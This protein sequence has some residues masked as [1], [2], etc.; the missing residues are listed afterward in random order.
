MIIAGPIVLSTNILWNNW[1]FTIFID[2]VWMVLSP[3]WC[4][5][6]LYQDN[7][8]SGAGRSL[9]WYFSVAA[10]PKGAEGTNALIPG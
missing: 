5:Y 10:E 8:L 3:S 7:K 4:F 2:A 6:I 1:F 9:A